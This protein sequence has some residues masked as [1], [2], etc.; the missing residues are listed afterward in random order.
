[1]KAVKMGSIAQREKNKLVGVFA[2]ESTI[3][4]DEKN[5]A[6]QR[7]RSWNGL[8]TKIWTEPTALRNE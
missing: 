6:Q 4:D 7:S 8:L 2:L 5:V 1:M 3:V